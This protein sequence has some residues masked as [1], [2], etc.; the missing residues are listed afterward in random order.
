MSRIASPRIPSAP[1]SIWAAYSRDASALAQWHDATPDLLAAPQQHPERVNP[2]A[3]H[4]SCNWFLPVFDNP[5][6]GGIMTILRLAAHLQTERGM[7]SR[8][9]LCGKANTA[10][11][12]R[13]I[14]G[15]FA[16]LARSSVISLDSQG[17]MDS[18][19]A[20]DYSV[21]TLWTTAYVLLGVRNTGLK[22][23]MIQD[24]EPLFYPAGSTYAQA[25][26]TY[27]FG[28][29]GIA[30]TRS[31]Q[32]L[33]EREYGGRAVTLI[34]CVDTSLFSTGEPFPRRR[35]AGPRRLFYYARPGTPRNGFELAAQAFRLL[36]ARRGENVDIVCAGAQWNPADHHLD[37]VVRTIGML[38]YE[39]TPNLYRSCDAGMALMMTRHPSYLPFE[40]MACGCLVVA[41]QNDANTWFLRHGDNCLLAAPT[42]S[43]LAETLDHALSDARD[44]D[45]IRV[46]AA[47]H[48]RSHHSD[49]DVSMRS[50][51][52]F[53]FSLTD[54]AEDRTG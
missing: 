37:G 22:F 46:R 24:Y 42:A 28:F 13:L 45:A 2:V 29:Y 31:L 27:R 36:K 6:Y 18:I 47:E 5:Y 38:P 19:P 43:C 21:C 35:Q 9:L 20:S 34:P 44:L 4:R 25:E 3:S 54:P 7:T 14:G 40:L 39:E 12:R 32:E 41:N 15:A 10:H 1:A 33:Y 48:I 26:L 23:T 17:A 52:R 50:V 16:S 8:F 51:A 11:I 49:W 30:N 53:M